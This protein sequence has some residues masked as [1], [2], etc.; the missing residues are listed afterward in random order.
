[1]TNSKHLLQQRI[2]TSEQNAVFTQSNGDQWHVEIGLRH[3]DTRRTGSQSWWKLHYWDLLLS[4]Q[5]LPAICHVSSE[6][7]FHKNCETVSQ[8]VLF[9]DTNISQG[10]VATPTRCGGIFN[11]SSVANFQLYAA[12]KEFFKWV[13]I[14]QSYGQDFGVVFFGSWCKPC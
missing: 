6:F 11:D 13:N 7:I 8:G 12:V 2:K 5:L 9:S 10:N 3:C 1:M 4:Q 14:W